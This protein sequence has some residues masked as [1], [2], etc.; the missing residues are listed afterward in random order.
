M[1][2]SLALTTVVAVLLAGSTGGGAIPSEV[3]GASSGDTPSGLSST[4]RSTS[5]APATM[6]AGNGT[7]VPPGRILF[8][9][10]GADGVERYFTI[11]TDGTDERALFEREGCMCADWSADGTHILSI[12]ATGHG[13]F[14]LLTIKP[15]GSDEFVISPP[16]TTLNLFVGA[17][18]A[19]GRL[20]AFAGFDET[21][22]SRNGIYIA[23]PDLAD[24]RM[25]T[26][27]PVGA[28]GVEP[29]GVTPD[30]QIIFFAEV[31]PQE[32]VTHTGDLYVVNADGTGLRKLNTRGLSVAFVGPS[33]SMASLS[34]DGR[35]VAFAAYAGNPKAG[36]SAVYVIDLAGGRAERVTGYMAGI[37]N[38]AWS[39][40][41]HWIAFTRQ[42]TGRTSLVSPDGTDEKDLSAPDE[43]VGFPSWSPEGSYMVV[44]RGGD[45]ANDLWIMDLDGQ[46]IGQVTREPSNYGVFSWAPRSGNTP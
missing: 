1:T 40:A 30:G 19:D 33:P 27:V 42:V 8:M 39:P 14:S 29:Y 2:R 43:N 38:V 10:Q 15:D 7:P 32:F 5:D 22:P 44:R 6:R 16:I 24:L 45:G 3:T 17:S 31:G 26:P 12:G 23:S 9:R 36:R 41:G 46:F 13:T 35:H 21:D 37:F 18:S 20:L 25:V 11:S 28:V 4:A 34:P